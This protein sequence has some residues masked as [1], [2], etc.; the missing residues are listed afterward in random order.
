M[1]TLLVL[2]A[3]EHQL[4]VIH[5][6]KR[7][8]VRV[9]TTDNVPDNPGHAIAD[10]CFGVD[11]TDSAAVLALAREQEID[12]VIAACTDVAVHTAAF[13]ADELQLPGFS[14]AAA[15]TLTDKA[16]FR[17]F[18]DDAGAGNPPWTEL[19]AQTPDGGDPAAVDEVL[20][21]GAAVLKPARSSGSKGTFVVTNRA[22]FDA[23][24]PETLSFGP[25]GRAV[26]E[27]FIDGMQ[28][29]IEGVLADGAVSWA[30]ITHRRTA[31]IPY[32]ATW[33]HILPSGLPAAAE[34][35][36]RA[37]IARL[38]GQFAITDGPFD[39]DFVLAGETIHILEV[40]P[41]LG[42]NALSALAALAADVDLP[43]YAV[44]HALGLDPAFVPAPTRPSAAILLGVQEPGRLYFDEAAAVDLRAQD[45]VHE[46][47][48]DHPIGAEV[49]PFV[50]GRHKIARVLL[51]GQT[52]DQLHARIAEVER[53]LDLRAVAG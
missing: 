35:A 20:A 15:L 27:A 7:L 31:P 22:E 48:I 8:G 23:R 29:T 37:E 26:L 32:C 13:V 41:R 46:L 14:T 19:T 47:S 11:T 43:M 3:S 24:L 42:G 44:R 9:L 1:P 21:G 50:S 2:A 53:R 12:G 39:A 18:L 52:P 38:L 45:W 49:F 28:G 33:G 6:A 34:A 36:I 17:R 4:P 16:L 25:D 30:L 5:A 51:T 10:A 40:S